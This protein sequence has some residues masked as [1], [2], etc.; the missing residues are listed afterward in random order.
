M[1]NNTFF[2]RQSDEFIQNFCPEVVKTVEA[3]NVK[4]LCL[5]WIEIAMRVCFNTAFSTSHGNIWTWMMSFVAF[6]KSDSRIEVSYDQFEIQPNNLT[7]TE[8]VNLVERIYGSFIKDHFQEQSGGKYIAYTP[9]LE[10]NTI[11]LTDFFLY[12]NAW[13]FII[14]MV[15]CYVFRRGHDKRMPAAITKSESV[16]T[17]PELSTV[18]L[19]AIEI[20]EE[21]EE[22]TPLDYEPKTPLIDNG[23]DATTI[24]TRIIT[25]NLSFK[26]ISDFDSM[27][28]IDPMNDTFELQ[29]TCEDSGSD[30]EEKV[31]DTASV[32]FDRLKELEK[33]EKKQS[34]SDEKVSPKKAPSPEK[35]PSK[36][37]SKN[38]LNINI[39]NVK[40]LTPY[41][42][43][44][45]LC[46]SSDS[47][48]KIQ[49]RKSGIPV[50]KGSQQKLAFTQ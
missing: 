50:R 6:S 34:A 15:T 29:G 1:L 42:D 25:D 18:V 46:K 24:S 10:P 4:E 16:Q 30:E 26:D 17:Q 48:S 13:L 44:H 12:L 9:F 8:C 41:K 23:A 43:N 27:D 37:P 45:R 32:L 7:R 38:F 40:Q 3:E 22:V 5:Q 20:L 36:K 33:A 2:Y 21:Q 39:E 19:S 11:C 47:D 31:Q 49:S 35:T 28:G 14:A